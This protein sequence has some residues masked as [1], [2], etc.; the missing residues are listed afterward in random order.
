M[1]RVLVHL[2]MLSTASGWQPPSPPPSPCAD[3]DARL[4]S[5]S[6]YT[7][8]SCADG[9]MNNGDH[10]SDDMF[11]DSGAPYGWFISLCPVTCGTCRQ[12]CSGAGYTDGGAA[13]CPEGM[14]YRTE[15]SAPSLSLRPC[16]AEHSFG[17]DGT[18]HSST[19]YARADVFDPNRIAE[20]CPDNNGIGQQHIFR[21]CRQAARDA[22]VCHNWDGDWS[23]HEC[24]EHFYGYFANFGYDQCPSEV[25]E[26]LEAEA[27]S[28]G[29]C[30]EVMATYECR[31]GGCSDAECCGAPSSGTCWDAGFRD[32][33]AAAV[34]GTVLCP[35]GQMARGQEDGHLCSGGPC[36]ASE[37]CYKPMGVSEF[38]RC[39]RASGVWAG[40]DQVVARQPAKLT[41]RAHLC[42]RQCMG[43]A[44]RR[45]CAPVQ[46]HGRSYAATATYHNHS[47]NI[48]IGGYACA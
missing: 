43:T 41:L 12:T 4:A 20:L 26:Q 14:V 25:I 27:A 32:S 19:C 10:C 15:Y 35:A 29:Q 37:C 11:V 8:M 44:D 13:A 30:S 28:G 5:D 21:D 7:I 31:T 1:G 23:C 34:D 47:G 48:Y 33:S 6:Q 18:I 9:F 22:N 42:M 40:F 16:C 39:A 36:F 24:D 38:D 46:G 17:E 3:D 45:V 2:A